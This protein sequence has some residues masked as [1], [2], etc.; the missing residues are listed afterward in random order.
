MLKR[1]L[2]LGCTI[3]KQSSCTRKPFKFHWALY[4]VAFSLLG[5]VFIWATH[6]VRQSLSHL[7]SFTLF[8]VEKAVD[9]ALLF[10]WG[11]FLFPAPEITAGEDW[12]WA[13][14]CE[15][16]CEGSF[17]ESTSWA[18]LWLLLE[19]ICSRRYCLWIRKWERLTP[20]HSSFSSHT[21]QLQEPGWLTEN[22]VSEG[23]MKS[24]LDLY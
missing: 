4:T 24:H 1:Y 14:N 21:K 8:V 12:G 13:G 15:F 7:L 16:S 10:S 5:R 17:T 18:S 9:F 19:F 11:H 6:L 20:S 2:K 3:E 22:L 23:K